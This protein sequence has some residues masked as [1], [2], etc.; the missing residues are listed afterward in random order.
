MRLPKEG[1]IGARYTGE[2][3]TTPAQEEYIQ[4]QNPRE[5]KKGSAIPA[6]DA[7]R[8]RKMRAPVAVDKSQAPRAR[9]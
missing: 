7:S 4:G 1:E 3:E 2:D 6:L 9:L 5:K 8:F